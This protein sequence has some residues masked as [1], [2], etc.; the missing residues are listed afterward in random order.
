MKRRSAE[1]IERAN[2]IY[3]Q[4]TGKRR[5]RIQVASR[6]ERTVQDDKLGELVFDSRAEAEHFKARRL[7]QTNG[8]ITRMLRQVPFLLPGGVRYRLDLLVFW[9]GGN[10]TWEDVKGHRTEVYNLKKRQVEALYRIT[11]TEIDARQYRKKRRK[12]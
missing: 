1:E 2:R 5:G 10:I 4:L 3:R 6:S 7:I 12:P 11:I 9:T 8:G